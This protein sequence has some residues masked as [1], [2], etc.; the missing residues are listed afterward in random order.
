MKRILIRCQSCGAWVKQ[1][2]FRK[3]MSERCP[4]R[5]LAPIAPRGNSKDARFRRHLCV[6]C[7]RPAIYGEDRCYSCNCD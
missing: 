2:R 1:H 6:D 7:G 5:L 3:H 4:R